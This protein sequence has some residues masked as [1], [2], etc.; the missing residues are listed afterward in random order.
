MA[1]RSGA[2]GAAV[3]GVATGNLGTGTA[4]DDTQVY[5]VD[6]LAT[7]EHPDAVGS[8]PQEE[9]VAEAPPIAARPVAASQAAAAASAALRQAPTRPV[10]RQR[11]ITGGYPVGILMAGVI[12][13]VVVAAVLTMRDGGI[14]GGA[15]NGPGLAGAASFPPPP[16][17]GA[18]E[19]AAPKATRPPKHHGHGHGQDSQ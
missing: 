16:S 6:A 9:E 1:K 5:S 17:F 4:L 7:A 13:L 18:L 15:A 8:F 19:T 2:P 11:R 10:Q 14:T 12:A 3:T